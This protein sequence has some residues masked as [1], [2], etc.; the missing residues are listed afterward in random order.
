MFGKLTKLGEN[1]TYENMVYEFKNRVDE[2][3]YGYF[4]ISFM[5]NPP[6]QICDF[7]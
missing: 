5:I 4:D 7:V 6:V 2:T 3:N 1:W